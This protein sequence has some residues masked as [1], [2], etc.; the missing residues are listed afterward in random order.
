MWVCVYIQTLDIKCCVGWCG[1]ASWINVKAFHRGYLTPRCYLCVCVCV[2]VYQQPAQ[3]ITIQYRNAQTFCVCH[4]S[5]QNGY[6]FIRLF[7]RNSYAFTRSILPQHIFHLPSIKKY[8][9]FSP[10]SNKIYDEHFFFRLFHTAF[11]YNTSITTE[12][13]TEVQQ[14]VSHIPTQTHSPISS[15]VWCLLCKHSCIE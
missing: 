1:A 4:Y 9:I 15:G 6:I 14:I 13:K 7:I 3:T 10:Q 8:T 5:I 11:Y 12:K 2:R